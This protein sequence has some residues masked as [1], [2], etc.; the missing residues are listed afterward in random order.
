MQ[1]RDLA[2][3]VGEA[4]RAATALQRMQGGQ[5][6]LAGRLADGVRDVVESEIGKE[7][8]DCRA[9]PFDQLAE[10]V[11]VRHDASDFIFL[12]FSSASARV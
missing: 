5:R 4:D 12:V 1:G 3:K 11:G 2:V 7:L 8:L 6:I 9:V 10:C